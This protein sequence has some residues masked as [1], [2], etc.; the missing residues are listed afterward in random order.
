MQNQKQLPQK[1]AVEVLV[2][3]A[4]AAAAIARDAQSTVTPLVA[5]TVQL[6]Y[7]LLWLFV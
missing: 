6:V 4:I 1:A 3:P 2:V 5:T 7:W